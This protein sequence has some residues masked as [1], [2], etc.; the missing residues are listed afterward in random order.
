MKKVLHIING[1]FFAGAERVQDLLAARLP[2]FDYEVVFVTLKAG[3]FASH[4]K[5]EAPLYAIEMRSQSDLSPVSEICDLIEREGISLIHSH[6]VRSALIAMCCSYKTAI[7][8]VH[9]VHSPA[10]DDTESRLRNIRNSLTERIALHR[11][12]RLLPVSDSLVHYVSKRGYAAHKVHAVYNGVPVQTLSQNDNEPP[13]ICCVAL[14]RPRKGIDCLIEAFASLR[15]HCNAKLQLVGPFETPEYEKQIRQQCDALNLGDSIEF[16]GFCEDVNAQ[17]AQADVFCL[18]S[19]YGEGMPMVILEAMAAGLPIVSTDVEG[20]PEQ[21]R[22]GTDGIL[23]QPGDSA[24]LA[25][26]LVL[27]CN[28]ASKR[29][30]MGAQARDRQQQFFSDLSMAR[31]TAD[32]YNSILRN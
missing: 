23:V 3:E 32:V 15:E 14:M 24:A 6:T 4:Y 19:L 28:D 11:A 2:H 26:A 16:T 21:V 10:D 8:M 31:S 29:N 17:L 20:I 30:E 7:P 1:E 9:H 18:P 5:S 13:V 27:M 12:K 22:S 25:D